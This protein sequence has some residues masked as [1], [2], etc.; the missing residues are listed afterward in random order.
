MQRS[1]FEDPCLDRALKAVEKHDGSPPQD[2]RGRH[3]P[4]NKTAEEQVEYVK[5]HISSFPTYSS[6]Y[7]RADNPNPNRK[8]L[9]A[10]LSLSEMYAL[11]K[12]ECVVAAAEDPIEPVSEW[13]VFNEEFN[14][15]S[16]RYIVYY[17]II[18][19]YSPVY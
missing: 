11:Y 13:K 8:Y 10:Q 5:K 3:E 2:Q 6:H 17:N 19:H 1:I 15:S 9:S 18:V 12:D 14:L 4:K 16:G 7:S